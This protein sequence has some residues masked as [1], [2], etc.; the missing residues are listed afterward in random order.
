MKRL[1]V[2]ILSL[3]CSL[4]LQAQ[5]SRLWSEG[6]LSWGEFRS[7]AGPDDT[8]AVNSVF[9]WKT[10]V[11]RELI[12]RTYY[13]YPTVQAALIPDYSYVKEGYAT[14][15]E[16]LR[17]QRIFD[18]WEVYARRYRDSLIFSIGDTRK[19]RTALIKDAGQAIDNLGSD[20]SFSATGPDDFE[21]PSLNC[22]KNM[23]AEVGY[24]YHR[25]IGSQ[26]YKYVHMAVLRADYLIGR[27][28][29][30]IETSISINTGPED[31]IYLNGKGRVGYG[32]VR[33]GYSFIDLERLKI[34]AF[35]GAGIAGSDIV[36]GDCEENEIPAAAGLAATAGIAGE[37]SYNI[38]SF[39]SLNN[40]DPLKSDVYVFLN[41]DAFRNGLFEPR[42]P[43]GRH[44]T[45][46][47]VGVRLNYGKLILK[48]QYQ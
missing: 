18:I 27:H 15:S 22:D 7:A 46:V 33:Y 5:N 12:G 40:R 6:A 28:S 39:V 25:F 23:A 20:A 30:G 24:R 32:L 26:N 10:G 11:K 14:D 34:R 48:K 43:L 13:M 45:G 17:Q 8:A 9:Y 1:L 35:I 47:S 38:A 44:S 21:A 4:G 37:C 29:V 2:L 3:S 41:V 36:D 19:I 31:P 16:L 42:C